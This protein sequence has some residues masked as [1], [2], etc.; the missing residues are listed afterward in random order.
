M[1]AKMDKMNQKKATTSA[2]IGGGIPNR[3]WPRSITELR[4]K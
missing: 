1:R 4:I 3:K 2:D